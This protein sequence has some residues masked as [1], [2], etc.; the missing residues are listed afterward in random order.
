[1]AKKGIVKKLNN[2]WKL[3][4]EVIMAV[5]TT[6]MSMSS[7]LGTFLNIHRKVYENA[8]YIYVCGNL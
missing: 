4:C 3:E 6:P 7:L 2:V 8:R 5:P 1:M